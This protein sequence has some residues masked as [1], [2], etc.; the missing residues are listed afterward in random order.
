M[1]AIHSS[2]CGRMAESA[3]QGRRSSGVRSRRTRVRATRLPLG[4]GSRRAP[5]PPVRGAARLR[6]DDADGIA[7]PIAVA[8]GEHGDREPARQV[9]LVVECSSQ[10]LRLSG[11]RLAAERAGSMPTASR[12][13]RRAD[14]ATRPRPPNRE[15]RA[16][17]AGHTIGV[18]ER[19]CDDGGPWSV[20]ASRPHGPDA[21]AAALGA[22]ERGREKRHG[23][24][25]EA[26]KRGGRAAGPSVF[27]RCD[28]AGDDFGSSA[29]SGTTA[30][31]AAAS[32]GRVD[33]VEKRDSM[34]PSAVPLVPPRRCCR[35]PFGRVWTGRALVRARRRGGSLRIVRRRQAGRAPGCAAR[36]PGAPKPGV[37]RR[38]L[39]A[40]RRR[41]AGR[42]RGGRRA[43]HRS[44][45]RTWSASSSSATSKPPA[46]RERSVPRRPAP[47]CTSGTSQRR[48]P[49]RRRSDGHRTR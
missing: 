38:P 14:P 3:G 22:G 25:T 8:K 16:L 36:D 6:A 27:D 1:S 17:R 47:A 37:A 2:H 35:A 34:V 29:S 43:H 45:R 18:V 20:A 5:R 4:R 31:S 39:R 46:T 21:D 12:K 11:D 49:S 19:R 28:H 7:N 30:S 10:R 44:A 15:L 41:G 33:V 40:R 24:V 48:S 42:G 23:H 26:S 32:H 13:H 9:D